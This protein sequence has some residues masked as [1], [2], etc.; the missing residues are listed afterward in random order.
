MITTRYPPFDSLN[1]KA[2]YNTPSSMYIKLTFFPS[3]YQIL[4]NLI[5][6]KSKNEVDFSFPTG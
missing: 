6:N 2:K 1:F 4:F 5:A 3:I